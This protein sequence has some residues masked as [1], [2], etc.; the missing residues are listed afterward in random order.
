M[1][2]GFVTGEGMPSSKRPIFA[3]QPQFPFEGC[4]HAVDPMGLI[5]SVA[6]AKM[7]FM[8]SPNLVLPTQLRFV[9]R[10]R[11]VDATGCSEWVDGSGAFRQGS[12]AG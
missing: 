3:L 11:I 12:V 4:G 8:R 1:T 7:I 9:V 2:L 6:D 5:I 10:G